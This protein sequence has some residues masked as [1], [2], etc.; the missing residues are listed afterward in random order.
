LPTRFGYFG[1]LGYLGYLGYSSFN[2]LRLFNRYLNRAL[3]ATPD[4]NPLI[5]NA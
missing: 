2:N 5:F 4:V 3:I 1:Y